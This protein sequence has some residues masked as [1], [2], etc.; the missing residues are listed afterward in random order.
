MPASKASPS[1]ASKVGPSPASEASP[2]AASKAS[3]SATSKASLSAAS[4][5]SPLNTGKVSPLPASK[6]SLSPT[7]KASPSTASQASPPG[8]ST[9]SPPGIC[10][11]RTPATSKGSPSIANTASPSG[12]STAKCT[13]SPSVTLSGDNLLPFPGVSKS[14]YKQQGEIWAKNN[15]R[16]LKQTET[17]RIKKN[18]ETI[19]T[20][21]ERNNGTLEENIAELEIAIGIEKRA[22]RVAELKSIVEVAKE[23]I[24]C[25]VLP[26]RGAFD[27]YW[28][29]KNSH[30]G[31]E[32]EGFYRASDTFATLSQHLNIAQVIVSGK[33]YLC[34]A[35]NTDIT[36]LQETI[37]MTKEHSGNA[38]SSEVRKQLNNS[39]QTAL[40]C[41]DT[42]KDRDIFMG[43]FAHL[44][45][46][47]TVMRLRNLQNRR[48]IVR[49]AVRTDSLF[50][51]Y[52]DISP[53]CSQ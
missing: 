52:G 35:Y 1:A 11:A 29:H 47:N 20:C 26:T 7:S 23:I 8:T 9:A 24:S 19:G 13:A 2:S 38:F 37:L 44:T 42:K 41:L 46:A 49:Q 36:K 14:F 34:E 51:N 40:S 22:K 30:L 15:S 28:K 45:S 5:A 12:T 16:N 39:F 53:L 50:R 33:A 6:A 27:L 48:A 4:K 18:R 31:T 3:P 32:H 17:I 21:K 10:T 43:I 25:R